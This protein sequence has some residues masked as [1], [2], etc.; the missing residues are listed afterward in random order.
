MIKIGNNNVLVPNG[1]NSGSLN[2]DI[3]QCRE[4]LESMKATCEPYEKVIFEKLNYEGLKLTLASKMVCFFF[5]FF[6]FAKKNFLF[7]RMNVSKA[8]R[9]VF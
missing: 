3:N 4:L 1:S 8:T 5:F 6:V 9:M 7:A 2:M